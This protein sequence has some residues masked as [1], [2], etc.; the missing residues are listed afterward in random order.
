MAI[1]FQKA[2]KKQSRLRL[3]IA[4]PAGSGKTYTALRIATEMGGKI[5][6]IDT[7]RGSASKYADIF[8]FDVIELDDFHPDRYIE[9]M[10]AAEKAGYDIL[11]IDSTTHEWNGKNGILELHEACVQKQRT[12]NSYTA[13]AEIT[14]VHNA[15]VN[16]ILGSKCHVIASVRSK[17][18]YVQEKN[19]QTGR[20][21]I[22]KVGMASIQRDGMDYEYDI[23]LEMSIDHVGVVT[24]TRCADLDG[25]TFK[26][27]GPEFAE[28]VMGWL[29][30]GAP[31][32]KPELKLVTEE[33]KPVETA[34]A[35]DE[36]QKL[37]DF[38][39]GQWP[40]GRIALYDEWWAGL[41]GL[42]VEQIK[43]PFKGMP[44][45]KIATELVVQANLI[46]KAKQE[47]AGQVVEGEVAESGVLVEIERHMKTLEQW[48]KPEQVGTLVMKLTQGEELESC[49]EV[50]LQ[51]IASLLRN[52]IAEFSQGARK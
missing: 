46:D 49:G 34:P 17:S 32:V 13:W 35:E 21:E 44:K 8:D 2:T 16:A 28:I 29:G 45:A 22:K 36:R 4:G 41:A 40:V 12:K 5:A 30:S 6:F 43:E 39:K 25:K 47:A 11:I 42:T 31:S 23:M 18:D 51:Q 9:A 3:S 14:P 33:P 26:K 48:M 7:E 50:Q 19:E 24:K 52:E 1:N 10:R 37:H 38:L 15:F 27:P 20:T